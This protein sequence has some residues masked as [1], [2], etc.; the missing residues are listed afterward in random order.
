MKCSEAEELLNTVLA[1]RSYKERIRMKDRL[2]HLREDQVACEICYAGNNDESLIT[3]S[4]KRW[5]E[6]CYS[7]VSCSS[8]YIGLKIRGDPPLY[9][10]TRM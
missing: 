5:T 8:S 7:S 10:H 3:I 1:R 9:I 6:A 4:S 2:A